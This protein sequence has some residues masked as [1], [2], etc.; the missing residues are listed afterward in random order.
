[1]R[2]ATTF[3]RVTTILFGVAVIAL[4]AVALGPRTGAYRT[5]T[6]LSDSMKPAFASGDVL[7]VTPAPASSV[8]AGDV[9]TFQAPIDGRPV[10]THRVIDVVSGGSA[11]R[12]RTRGD[13]N[14]AA[15]P[16]VARLDGGTIWRTRAVV[17]LA[18]SAIRVLRTKVVM[19]GSLFLAPLTL[20]VLALADIWSGRSRRIELLR[21]DAD[22]TWPGDDELDRVFGHRARELVDLYDEHLDLPGFDQARDA[23]G[24]LDDDWTTVGATTAAPA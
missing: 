2:I 22:W 13:A 23:W 18:G 12:V 6:V 20:L 21:T 10:V 4:A 1:M 19:M 14:R 15:D 3:S 8:R 16:W 11:P 9:I 17:P 7:L 24:E 5:V